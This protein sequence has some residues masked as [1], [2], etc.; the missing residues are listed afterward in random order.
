MKTLSQK[1]GSFR[2]LKIAKYSLMEADA[3]LDSMTKQCSE[4]I[5]DG[6]ETQEQI[7]FTV[8]FTAF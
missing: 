4:G 7:V 3:T 6:E 8:C 2:T 5:T 1:I